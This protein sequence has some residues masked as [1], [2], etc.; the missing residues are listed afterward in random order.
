MKTQRS[1][2]CC[3]QHAF[4]F[5]KETNEKYRPLTASEKEAITI[6]GLDGGSF[7][8]VFLN[9]NKLNTETKQLFL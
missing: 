3:Y 7:N 1:I 6:E 8:S 4:E 2:H 9:F 5:G